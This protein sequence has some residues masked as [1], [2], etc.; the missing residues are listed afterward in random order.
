MAKDPLDTTT[1]KIAYFAKAEF[2]R[3]VADLYTNGTRIT[4]N[5]ELI[6]ALILAARRAA[7]GEIKSAVSRY[8]ERTAAMEAQSA[9]LPDNE[10][11]L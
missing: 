2:D 6:G 1:I 3:L 9:Q 4:A 7:I 8:W 11:E 5:E 10:A